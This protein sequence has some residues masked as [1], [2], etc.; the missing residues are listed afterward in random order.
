MLINVLLIFIPISLGLDHIGANPIVV[1][2]TTVLAVVPL[3]VLI[4]HATENLSVRLGAT[5][6]GLL[7]G[8]MGNVPEMIIAISA[9][10]KGLE[11]MVKTSLTGTL[12][13]NV[14][15]VLGLSIIVGCK[16]ARALRIG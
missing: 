16:D 4:G 11:P 1:F 13:S 10:R 2:V 3:T 12:L 9:L 7:N 8:T 5:L 6:G 14:L 15:V